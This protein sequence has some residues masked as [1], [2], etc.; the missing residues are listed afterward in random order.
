[1][2]GRVLSATISLKYK[3]ESYMKR[4]EKYKKTF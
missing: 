4:W 3:D 1:M 2:N